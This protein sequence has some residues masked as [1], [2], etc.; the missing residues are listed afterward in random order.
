MVGGT[1]REL[2][3]GGAAADLDLAVAGGALALGRRLADR[4]D[5][6]F[7]VLDEERGAGR[8]VPRSGRPRWIWWISA[9]RR[10]RTTCGPATSR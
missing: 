3:S 7:V 5:A 4:L 6:T 10:S 8:I 9:R 1:L 2:L